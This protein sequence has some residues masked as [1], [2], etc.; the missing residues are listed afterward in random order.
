MWTNTYLIFS[1]KHKTRSRNLVV[2][3]NCIQRHEAF[4]VLTMIQTWPPKSLLRAINI[5][6]TMEVT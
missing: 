1:R 3:L 2:I 4:E 6:T 5:G